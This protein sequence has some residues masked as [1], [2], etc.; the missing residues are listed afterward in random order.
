MSNETPQDTIDKYNKPLPFWVIALIP[1]YIS[2]LFIVLFFP[3]AQDWTWIEAWLFIISFVLNISISYYLINKKNPRVIRNRMKLKKVGVT[4]KTKKS[5]GSDKFIMP[6]LA[7]GLIGALILPVFD[8]RY[9]WTIIPFMVEI[10]GLVI[11]NNGLI[12]MDI[13]MVQNAY[14]S[15]ILDINKDQKLI[16]TGLYGHVRHPLYSGAVLMMLGLPIALGSWISLIPA[17]VGIVAI[18]I[19]IK[20]EEDMLIKGMVGYTEYQTRVKYK[21]IPKIY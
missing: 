20:F 8:F 15:K 10:I 3:I 7:I 16:D 2:L 18:I 17:A 12:I 21:I 19:R 4:E 5:V 11:L 14:A 9:Q 13:A 1:V 6:F